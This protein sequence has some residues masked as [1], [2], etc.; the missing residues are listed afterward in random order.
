MPLLTTLKTTHGISVY[1]MEKLIDVMN[2][3]I[4][5]NHH[6]ND[7]VDK[8]TNL[9]KE[10]DI[11]E[12]NK[13]NQEFYKF[14]TEY[15]ELNSSFKTLMAE[16]NLTSIK[17][18]PDSNY[19]SGDDLKNLLS[20]FENSV[21]DTQEKMSALAKLLSSELNMINKIKVFKKGSTLDLKL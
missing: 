18:I 10:T 19:C 12:I 15:I 13:A 1:N 21:R 16:H 5:G 4:E 6:V 11:D 20:T 14:M 8:C 3:I 2:Q 9:I 7:Y 17:N